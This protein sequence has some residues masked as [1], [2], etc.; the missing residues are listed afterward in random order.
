[1]ENKEI[2]VISIIM[3]IISNLFSGIS[4]NNSIPEIDP[5]KAFEFRALQKQEQFLTKELQTDISSDVSRIN[6]LQRTIDILKS[7]LSQIPSGFK[8]E[9]RDNAERQRNFISG[10]I[11]KSQSELDQRKTALGINIQEAVGIVDVQNW[12]NS[13]TL[14]DI[15]KRLNSDEFSNF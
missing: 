8:I 4:G 15:R 2:N 6:Q 7:S 11:G 3:G 5:I 14:D 12:Y 9:E 1:M 10:D 13:A